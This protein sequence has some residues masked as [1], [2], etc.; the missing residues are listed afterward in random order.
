MKK[1][2]LAILMLVVASA[3]VAISKEGKVMMVDSVKMEWEAPGQDYYLIDVKEKV[4]W[5][6]EKTGAKLALLKSPVG[7]IDN[8]HT[9]PSNQWAYLL[10]GSMEGKFFQIPAGVVHGGTIVKEETILLIF[11]DGPR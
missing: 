11:W 8:P 9:H 6:D 3:A 10:S 7:K 5:E 2:L 4:L 1:L